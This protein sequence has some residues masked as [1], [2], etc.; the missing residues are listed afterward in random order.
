MNEV[1]FRF[2]TTNVNHSDISKL[3]YEVLSSIFVGKHL[4]FVLKNYKSNAVSSCLLITHIENISTPTNIIDVLKS[5][6]ATDTSNAF[7]LQKSTMDIGWA[8]S[9]SSV[10]NDTT[11]IDSLSM[12][13]YEQSSLL[14]NSYNETDLS[15][16]T[17]QFWIDFFDE[18]D[19]VCCANE[20]NDDTLKLELE[21]GTPGST[22][23]TSSIDLFETPHLCTRSKTFTFDA[24]TPILNS[25][26]M[27]KGINLVNDKEHQTSTPLNQH[28]SSILRH[29]STCSS[30]E[31]NDTG[32]Y[33]AHSPDL[34][35]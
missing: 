21:E 17:S 19:T 33:S 3:L 25:L 18:I 34:F 30:L 9:F 14:S 15:N 24:D 31:D 13:Q 20:I 29:T 10:Y 16:V 4:K 5:L 26:K 22:V 1:F 2:L 28:S 12:I 23:C 11:F 35:K 27:Y 8:N 32:T 6:H 7:P